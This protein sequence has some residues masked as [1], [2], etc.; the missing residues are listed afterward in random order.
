MKKEGYYKEENEIQSVLYL[1]I[2][3]FQSFIFD[4]GAGAGKTYSLK[5]SLSYILKNKG[6]DLE[7][8]NRNIMCIT[9][10]NVAKNEIENR[11]GS[12]SIIEVST[13]HEKIW[14]LISSYQD[15]LIELHTE[16]IKE[17]IKKI[18]LEISQINKEKVCDDIRKLDGLILKEDFIEK[19]YQNKDLS[20]SILKEKLLDCIEIKNKGDFIKYVNNKIKIAKY[21]N[22]REKGV[23][24]VEYNTLSKFERL[25]KNEISHDTLLEYG[26]KM[27]EKYDLLKKYIVQK[28][29]YILVDEYQDTNELVVKMLYLLDKYSKKNKCEFLV[30]YFGDSA[31]QIYESGIGLNL[32]DFHKDLKKI[33]KIYN[34]RSADEI[35]KIGNNIRNFIGKDKLFQKSIYKDNEKGLFEIYVPKCKEK[36]SILNIVEEVI[37]EINSQ[38]DFLL[39]THEKISKNSNFYDIYETLKETQYYSGTVND[40]NKEFMNLKE[41]GKVPSILYELVNKIYLLNFE[42]DSMMGSF[43]INKKGREKI[44]LQH[45]EKYMKR[46][47][48]SF[49]F[50]SSKSLLRYLEEL[51]EVLNIKKY[52][53]LNNV[54][55]GE[56]MD[57]FKIVNK[58]EYS[59]SSFFSIIYSFLNP[60]ENEKLV[61]NKKLVENLLDINICQYIDWYKLISEKYGD[62]SINFHTYHGT[63]GEE[64]DNV[65][66]ILD[67]NFGGFQLQF[68]KFFTEQENY[69]NAGKVRNLLYVACTRAK[70]NLR[71]IC[72]EKFNEDGLKKVFGDVEIKE[73]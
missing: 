63:K 70:K 27:V 55:F 56:Y 18:E 6:K 72:S 2:D 3:K 71:I 12:S 23:Q 24:K 4:S 61:E 57:Y 50:D 7:N 42:I 28:Y 49:D 66:I 25:Y 15:E 17:E 37:K 5:E 11:I 10:T 29:P 53:D 16:K 45:L 48:K 26:Y 31:Q 40:L 30:G 58:N 46:I 47:R 32:P 52:E 21:N 65:I 68:D 1:C 51:V 62:E 39:L 41:L 44:T 60:K 38:V 33:E 73:F 36:S 14:G 19:Y 69:K 67:K 8:K 34:R 35:I 43:L 64:Y 9:Y 13:I 22:V 54:S 20:A 59:V